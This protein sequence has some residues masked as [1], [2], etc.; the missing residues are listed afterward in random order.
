MAGH[1]AAYLSD[2]CLPVAASAGRRGRLR[3]ASSDDLLIPRYYEDM[4]G[5][6]K[7]RIWGGLG[8]RITGSVTINS[9][10]GLTI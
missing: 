2:M 5:N 4:K 6:A 10:L 3:S 1:T 8:V 9:A 7:Y